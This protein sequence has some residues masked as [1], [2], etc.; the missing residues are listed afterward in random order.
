MSLY[1]G[2]PWCFSDPT[3]SLGGELCPTD[4]AANEQI[5]CHSEPGATSKACLARACWCTQVPV[6]APMCITPKQDGYRV[7]GSVITT[8][9]GYQAS[10][11]RVN[12]P[13]WY[14]ADIQTV[15]M[16]VEFHTEN[17]L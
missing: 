15:L 8:A 1:T 12:S 10:L 14:G 11:A 9:K 2:I 16:E 13:S 17:R 3:A 6:G 7:V 5:D 4:V